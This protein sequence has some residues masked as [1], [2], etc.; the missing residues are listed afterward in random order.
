MSSTTIR[1]IANYAKVSIGTVSNVINHPNKVADE[2]RSRVLAAIEALG[3]KSKF[4]FK[5]RASDSKFIGLVLPVSGNSFFEEFTIGIED[6]IAHAGFSLLVGYSR[7]DLESEMN[8][9]TSLVDA[10]FMGVIVVPIGIESNM[11]EKFAERFVRVAYIS[12]TEKLPD[13][14][15]LSIDQLHGGSIS[16]EFLRQQGHKNIMWV[17]GPDSHYPS[18]QRLI[19]MT[20]AA[21]DLG[22]VLTTKE[23][24]SLDH[25]SGLQI[26]QEIIAAGPLPDAIIAANDIIALAIINHFS[27]VGLNVPEDVSVLGYDNASYSESGLIALSTVSQTPY[28]LGTI[29]AQQ[30]L[31]DVSAGAD[32]VHEHVVY[33]PYIVERGSTKRRV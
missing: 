16:V 9:V 8:I 1:D 18:L 17:S 2:T 13:L 12:Q 32:H 31:A 3:F 30:M 29:V 22:V 23:A 27:S 26:A 4:E 33:R 5:R 20:Q 28:H 25:L 11:F 6:E 10:G 14:C 24:H 21:K 7:D 19:G 15:S